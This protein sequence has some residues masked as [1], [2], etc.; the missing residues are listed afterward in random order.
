MQPLVLSEWVA[1]IVGMPPQMSVADEAIATLVSLGSVEGLH[2]KFIPGGT[3]SIGA[4]LSSTVTVFGQGGLVMQPLASVSV[5]LR[6]KGEWQ[7]GP[8]VTLTDLPEVEPTIVPL[9][10]MVQ[11]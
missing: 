1:V 11:A 10:L 9:P 6:V 7:R 5:R 4:V 8:A 3:V 2:P